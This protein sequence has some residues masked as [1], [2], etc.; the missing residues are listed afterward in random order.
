MQTFQLKFELGS[1]IRILSNSSPKLD[2]HKKIKKQNFVIG[3]DIKLRFLSVNT[4]AHILANFKK[5]NKISNRIQIF[6]ML[7]QSS[8]VVFPKLYKGLYNHNL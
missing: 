1:P 7:K 8:G 6:H 4:N 2:V 3:S 5:Y